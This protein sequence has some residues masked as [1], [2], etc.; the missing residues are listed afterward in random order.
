M[1]MYYFPHT[2]VKYEKEKGRGSENLRL[3]TSVGNV[4]SWYLESVLLYLHYSMEFALLHANI[5]PGLGMHG[6]DCY[7]TCMLAN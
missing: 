3:I 6:L 5:T 4:L 7:Y 2:K 1:W